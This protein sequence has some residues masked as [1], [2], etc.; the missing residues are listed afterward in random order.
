ME[1]YSLFPLLLWLPWSFFI[2][3]GY[4]QLLNSQAQV[5]LQLKKHLEYPK[6][7]DIWY[8]RRTLFCSLPP[9]PNVNVSCEFNSVTELKIMGDKL[10]IEFT[11]FH[12]FPVPNR[13]LSDAFS[14]DSFVTTL[15]RLP[16]LKVLALVSLGIWGP[17]PDKIHRLSSLESLDLSSNFL[18]GSIPPKVSTMVK[19]QTLVLDH[20]FFNDT[21]PNVF[22]SLSNLTSLSLKKN[23]L[24]GPFP[25]SITGIKTLISLDFS[26]NEIS[27]KLPDLTGLT[28][29]R[30]LDLSANNFDSHLPTIPK[31]LF[32]VSL[33][34]NS[35][36]GEIPAQ[37]VHPTHLQHIDISFNKLSGTI[38]APLFSLPNISFLN[39]ASNILSGSLGYNI[40]CGTNL[41]F[42]DISNN[43]LS[44][45]LPSCLNSES[46]NKV[47]NF[48]GNC[49]SINEHHRRHNQH[50]ESYCRDEVHKNQS[51]PNARGIGVS[52]GLI[53]GIAVISVLLAIALVI[54]CRHYC[55]RLISEQHLLHKSV[56]EKSKT[57]FS[58][59]ILTNA[60]YISDNAK[61]GG[62]GLPPCRSFTLEELKEATNNF[63][64]S[65][66]LGEGSYGKLF[67]GRLESG[68][69]VAIR[70]LPTTKKYW[71][72]NL[73]L[74]LDMLARIRHPHL[75]CILGHC[76]EVK[77]DDCSVNGVFLVYEYISNGNFR[78]HLSENC[79]GGVLNWSERLAILISVCKAVQFLHT[80]VI[81][82]FFH[83]R[84]KTNNI[85]LNQH[86]MAKL[87]DYA[88]S[89]ISEET[90]NDTAKGEDPHKSWQMTILEDDVYSFGLILLETMLG[91]SIAAKMEAT[92]QHELA[93]L[94]NQ[95]GRARLMNPVVSA[96]GS[97]ESLSTVISIANKC[98]CPELW[99]RPSFE[100][101]LWHLQYAAQI[102]ANAD[103]EPRFSSV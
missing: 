44:G 66:F 16:R 28:R 19:L 52:V 78:S 7:L 75:V 51:N 88:L 23:T 96:T 59:E 38:P 93:S 98:I 63:D 64:N 71:I 80:G 43:R 85:L 95:D 72:R 17:L 55:N 54:V 58:S 79:V 102:Q 10:S 57:G 53:V 21:V 29:L 27:G 36:T 83:N 18:Y 8:D 89:I 97:Q 86:R 25:S 34:K 11:D 87:G 60:R 90:N 67:K 35:F 91:S 81:P 68:I 56:Q 99:S 48:D 32:M 94:S 76:I 84:L 4:S 46:G 24:K 49:L 39:L 61:L 31:G 103:S 37:Y 101:I 33:E 22:D 12:G 69:H 6:Q 62:Q 26:S 92:L 82:G 41:G 30:L 40:T 20:N 100:D 65:A 73:K 13:T 3:G 9:S 42:V 15:S 45:S 70:C 47:V 5:L 77:Q 74:R 14:M 1:M 2:M 50:P